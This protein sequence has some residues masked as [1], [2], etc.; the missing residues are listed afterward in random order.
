[1][2][3]KTRQQTGRFLRCISFTF[4]ACATIQAIVVADARRGETERATGLQS[5]QAID[6]S[7]RTITISGDN[8]VSEQAW[9]LRAIVDSQSGYARVAPQVVDYRDDDATRLRDVGLL[10]GALPLVKMRGGVAEAHLACPVGNQD[11]CTF[12]I[13]CDDGNPCTNDLC[14]ISPQ[15]PL[16]GGSCVHQQVTT[17]LAGDCDDGVLCNGLETCDAA[18]QCAAGPTPT[19]CAGDANNSGEQCSEDLASCSSESSVAGRRCFTDGE[20]P[21]GRCDHCVPLCTIDADCDDG[22][23]CNGT[24]I[25]I[26]NSC[27]PGAPTCGFGGNCFENRCIGAFL[28][29]ACINDS[30]CL[31]NQTC[32]PKICSG[33]G[34]GA[35][36]DDADCNGGNTCESAHVCRLGRCCPQGASVDDCQAR[37]LS[38]CLATG[39]QWFAGDSGEESGAFGECGG[40]RTVSGALQL[41]CPVYSSGIMQS[42]TAVPATPLIVG[43]VSLSPASVFAPAGP[44]VSLQR[45]GDD[46]ELSG[47]SPV[48]LEGVR[49]VGGM[50]VPD[51]VFVEIWDED[52]N[53]I[54]DFLFRPSRTVAVNL[55]ELTPPL[56]IPPRG[57]ISIRN[58]VEFSANAK[59]VWASAASSQAGS[60]DPDILF[61]NDDPDYSIASSGMMGG[62]PAILA[63][64]L[65]GR[66]TS[67]PFGGC[68]H[69]NSL[70]CSNELQWVCE[71]SGNCSAANV[72]VG[73]VSDG[74]V[75]VD[76]ADCGGEFLGLGSICASCQN[77]TEPGLPCETCQGGA[78]P[79]E[80][81]CLNDS[82]CDAR[83]L[84]GSCLPN[85]AICAPDG[86]A[87]S[88]DIAENCVIGAN[89]PA[90]ANVCDN[91]DQICT[92]DVDCPPGGTCGGT[93]S[94]ILGTCVVTESCSVGACCLPDGSCQEALTEAGCAG[95]YQGNASTCS[96]NCCPAAFSTGMDDCADI[97]FNAANT[98]PVLN[99]GD[100]PMV[101]TFTGDNSSATSTD[102]DPD[103]CFGEARDLDDDRGWW[104]GFALTDS[105]TR[106]RI[107]LCCSVPVHFANWAWLTT[108]CNCNGIVSAKLDPNA[109]GLSTAERGAPFCNED[110]LWVN[111]GLLPAG[112]YY[113][114]IR[115]A[116][117]G[118]LGPY[119][120]HVVAEACPDAACCLP[121][122]T[123]MT[124]NQIE[125]DASGGFYLA[126]PNKFP[127]TT[128]CVSN[129]STCDIGACCTAPGECEDEDLGDP[130]AE[131]DCD[132]FGGT[133]IG[134][135]KCRGGICSLDE[136]FSCSTAQ[137]CQVQ[138]AGCPVAGNCCVSPGGDERALDQPNPCPICELENP[139]ACQS[140]SV[141][142][143]LAAI[144]ELSLGTGIVHADDFI[145]GAGLSKVDEVCVWGVYTSSD[146]NTP[147]LACVNDITSDEFRVRIYRDNGFNLPGQLL[148]ESTASAT[149]G[150]LDGNGIVTADEQWVSQLTL[151]T[152]ITGLTT[153][154]IHWLEVANDLPP[155]VRCYWSWSLLSPASS[156][157]NGHMAGTS[158][159]IG[160][161]AGSERRSDAAWCLA[162]TVSTPQT[163]VRVACGCSGSCIFASLDE[164]TNS[165]H[166]F[167]ISAVDGNNVPNECSDFVCPSDNSPDNDDFEN[168]QEVGVG[169]FTYETFCATTDGLAIEQS[170][171]GI[172]AVTLDVWYQF[173]AAQNCELIVSQ[174]AS[175]TADTAGFDAILGVYTDGSG[176]CP[177]PRTQ[178]VADMTR[179]SQNGPVLSD[180]ECCGQGE[181]GGGGLVRV[182]ALAGQ[183]FTI[184]AAAFDGQGNERGRGV[185]DI[186]CG[187]PI[188]G[189]GLVNSP[190]EECDGSDWV[191]CLIGA[192]CIPAGQPDECHCTFA[193]CGNQ[194]AEGTEE[195]DGIDDSLCPGTC[196]ASLCEC[197]PYCGNGLA[198][199][200]EACD[201]SDDALCVGR[202]LP[203]CTC[204]PKFCG[205]D[206]VDP[207]EE[208]DGLSNDACSDGVCRA[209]G[210]PAGECTCACEA[211]TPTVDVA[212][213]PSIPANRFL[214]I[215]I[216][217]G[218]N[219][220]PFALEVE[221]TSLYHPSKPFPPN[222]PDFSAFEGQVRYVRL[223][224]DENGDPLTDC[225][226]STAFGTTYKCATLG[227]QPEIIDWGALFGGTELYFTGN[228]IVPDSTYR[229]RGLPVNATPTCAANANYITTT[230]SRWGDVDGNTLTDVSDVVK[231]VNRVK[232]IFAAISETRA[233]F[234]P[235]SPTPHLSNPSVL[236]IT[237]VV[238][239]VK[240][241]AYPYP[242][243][244]CP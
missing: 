60:N 135:M 90:R 92:L 175:G 172:A 32:G 114:S 20:C 152:P 213:A 85:D 16:A 115:S 188:C 95:V 177:D 144:S 118:T 75:C 14:N 157:G 99:P 174:C 46:Y 18:G 204:P 120:M 217:S 48:A 193:I 189:D 23:S 200:S 197:V 105:C 102:A 223:I 209:P 165:N 236:D 158:E 173:T 145:P 194:I 73:G 45:L 137:D 36:T 140:E 176:T 111:M 9:L 27:V 125:C 51:A 47:S 234:S 2:S 166:S 71:T 96:P 55:L 232:D 24:E 160:Y 19:C 117:S 63:F 113:Y 22:L 103:S 67:L 69:N 1:M 5:K 37:T 235:A 89:C 163:P 72:C 43:P 7:R 17:G 226:D 116:L 80:F 146:P 78:E 155:E 134:G 220:E 208:C 183:C 216:P 195:C 210:D 159:T 109:P 58:K 167:Q 148:G 205:N 123:C 61:I 29:T 164:A 54:E 94:C 41:G 212:D 50:L 100:A 228:A 84:G 184:R 93:G 10:S 106:V 162:G 40:Q 8:D 192:G 49:I 244:T 237:I 242:I 181:C 161:V 124:V 149:R 21:G 196:N 178:A 33:P 240:L 13:D 83:G 11:C 57:R 97:V 142:T 39:G 79:G 91:A 66:S 225:L 215:L 156:Q 62:H 191:G 179:V 38:D 65:V 131:T 53:F 169:F 233:L 139:N 128:A 187:A 104:E 171:L 201:G 238:D 129:P 136:R 138:G 52:G 26:G 112:N 31:S 126:P 133:F 150:Q 222:P 44:G 206:V 199:P 218:T 34:G 82:D 141:S 12:D 15:G 42:S 207:G 108:D 110:N 147:N 132:F 211:C 59:F 143:D 3:N 70:T 4:I 186:S 221:L 121:N 74:E 182:P 154:E 107:D 101:L 239:A 87:C 229:V 122:G 28:T 241:F 230:T 202:C 243:S 64:E 56:T 88:N 180:E 224:R 227:C 231:V 130:V 153:G 30:D 190:A 219:V 168:A 68:C 25:C 198:E 151:D 119:T 214:S 203:D 35:C 185:I 127:A 86:G 6:L 81:S 170:E 98:I 77:G 76:D